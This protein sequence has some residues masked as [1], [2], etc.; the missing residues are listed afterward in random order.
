[1]RSYEQL[2]VVADIRA[3]GGEVYGLTSEP[4]SLAQE[5]EAAWDMSISVVGDPHHEIR[6]D[7]ARRGWLDVFANA[8]YGHLRERSW[9]NHPRGYFQPALIAL[10]RGGRVLYRWR[11][12]PRYN[13]MS[14]A[15]ARPAG[16]YV[17]DRIRAARADSSDAPDAPLDRG[18]VMGAPELPWWRFL[19]LLTAHGWFLRPRA[20]PLRRDGSKDAVSPRDAMRRVYWFAGAWVLAFAL[21]PLSWVLVGLG[22]WLA[23]LT[24]GMIE[25]HRQFQHASDD[26]VGAQLE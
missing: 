25:I 14:G 21:L 18:P 1:M 17:R 3:A 20:F 2:G 12:V 5:A 6:D 16:H 23:M 15:G 24:P 26:A 22:V 8:D 7:L 10:D 11:C 19:L 13:N 9:A 4:Q